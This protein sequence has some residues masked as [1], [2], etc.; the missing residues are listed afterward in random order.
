MTALGL[1]GARWFSRLISTPKRFLIPAILLFC[2]IGS[3]SINNSMFDIGVLIVS[4]LVG[5]A[6][7]KAGFPVAPVIL[8][9]ILGPMFESNMRRSLMLS[10]GNWSTFVTRPISLAFILVAIF[11]L[12]GP[13]IMNL[14]KRKPVK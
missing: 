6:L 9:L 11:V 4:G 8:G 14:L 1:L 13:P 7:R 10:Q 2:L 5:F 12:A 3:Y